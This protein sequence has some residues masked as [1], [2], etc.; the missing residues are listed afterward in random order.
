VSWFW[1]SCG[2]KKLKNGGLTSNT[3]PNETES[4]SPIENINPSRAPRIEDGSNANSNSDPVR[5]SSDVAPEPDSTSLDFEIEAPFHN[6][7]AASTETDAIEIPVEKMVIAVPCAPP[8]N[9][10]FSRRWQD[11]ETNDS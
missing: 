7:V 5:E 3:S 2:K 10:G 8:H 1:H 6:E 4:S 11:K 9:Q